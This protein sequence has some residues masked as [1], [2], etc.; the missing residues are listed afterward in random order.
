MYVV[1]AEIS[2]KHCNSIMAEGSCN[3]TWF[4]AGIHNLLAHPLRHLKLHIYGIHDRVKM[5]GMGSGPPTPGKSQVAICFLRHTGTDSPRDAI[6]PLESNHFSRE[7]RTAV[8][9]IS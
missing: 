1:P 9:E 4:H 6:R 3:I 7:V 5:L 8:C 2:K